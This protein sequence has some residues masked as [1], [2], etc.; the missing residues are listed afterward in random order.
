MLVSASSYKLGPERSILYYCFTTAVL[1]L[2]FCFTTRSLIDINKTVKKHA[3]IVPSFIGAHAFSGCDSVPKLYGI[4]KKTVIKAFKDQNLSLSCLG[5][6]ATS[7]T[8]VYAESR[9]LISSC[10]GVKNV[11][12]LSEVRFSMFFVPTIKLASGTVACSQDLR[13]WTCDR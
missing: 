7:L 13:K 1:L 10:Y 8:N 12:N 11:N 2:Y 4:G 3:E 5:G 6:T 9:K